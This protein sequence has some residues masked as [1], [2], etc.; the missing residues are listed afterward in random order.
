MFADSY[1][2]DSHKRANENKMQCAGGRHNMPPPLW[3]WLLSFWPWKWY[4]S[5][6]WLVLPL[7]QF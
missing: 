4:A 1:S 3:P 6:V 5:H 2:E 7:R